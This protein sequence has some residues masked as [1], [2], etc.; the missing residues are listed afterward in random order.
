MLGATNAKTTKSYHSRTLPMFPAAIAARLSERVRST[1]ST[2]P[3]ATRA[4][5]KRNGGYGSDR[6]PPRN[7]WWS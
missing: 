7:S 5:P 4:Q 2:E 3:D 6:N 1:V